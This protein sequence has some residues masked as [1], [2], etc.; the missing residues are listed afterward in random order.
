[1]VDFRVSEVVDLTQVVSGFIPK[2]VFLR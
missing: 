2:D 1:V